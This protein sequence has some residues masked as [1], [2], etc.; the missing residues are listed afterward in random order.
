MENICAYVSKVHT[1]R[2][3]LLNRCRVDGIRFK[4]YKLFTSLPNE[5]TDHMEMM[6]DHHFKHP[7]CLGRGANG[8]TVTVASGI[9]T[10]SMV[11]C[12]VGIVALMVGPHVSLREIHTVYI[13]N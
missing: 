5:Y 8:R 7:P 12:L 10:K 4:Q 13:H 1:P 3:F 6:C 11:F 2:E 9:Y